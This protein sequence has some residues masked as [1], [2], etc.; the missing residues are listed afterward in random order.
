MTENFRVE[1]TH[2]LHRKVTS[3]SIDD[4]I[5]FSAFVQT[6]REFSTDSVFA[7][8]NCV[9]EDVLLTAAGT[10]EELW[11]WMK[12]KIDWNHFVIRQLSEGVLIL[13]DR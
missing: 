5:Y 2:T 8:S 1:L 6:L 12:L 11:F 10:I 3:W 7:A 4:Q 9:D 13:S